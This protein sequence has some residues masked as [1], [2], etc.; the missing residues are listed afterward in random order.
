M[1]R[2]TTV[3]A[4]IILAL[5]A[6]LAAFLVP[7]RAVQ[8]TGDA[9][10]AVETV[11]VASGGTTDD[12][13][14]WV[15]PAEPTKS[16]IIGA[17]NDAGIGIYDLAGAE[18]RTITADGPASSVDVR[19]GFT[20]GGQ[21]VDILAA[22]NNGTVRFYTIDAAGQVTNQTAGT[23]AITPAWPSGGGKIDGLC[24]YQSSASG[25]P[26]TYAFVWAPTGQMEQLELIDN[27]GKIDVRLVRGGALGAWDVAATAGPTLSGCVADDELHTL[28][29]GEKTAAI[30]KFG[31]EPSASIT[32][33]ASVDVPAPTGHFTPNLGGLALV[34]TGPETGYLMASS[35]G[36]PDTP[37]A[38]SFMVYK[39]EG[40]N[41]FVR[42]FHVVTGAVDGCQKTRGIEAVAANLGPAFPDGVFVCQDLHNTATSGS[43]AGLQDYKLVPLGTIADVT[44]VVAQTTTTTTAPGPATTTTAPAV[45]QPTARRS[46]YWMVG[47]D[48]KVYPFGDAKGLGDAPVMPG[49]EA[50]DLEPTPSG[51]GYW[52]VDAAGHVYAMGDAGWLGNADVTKLAAGEKVTSISSTR[53]GNGYWIFTTRGRVLP[54]GAAAFHGDMSDIVLNG[55]VLDSIPS[56]SGNGYYMVASDGGIFTL[57]D[58]KFLGSMGDTKLN[59][60]VQSLV[61]SDGLGYWLVASDGGIFA[62][63]DAPFRG[64][65]GSAKL[66]K[67]VT[68][69]VR[70]GNGYLMVAEDGGIF[71]FSDRQ[72]FGSLGDR[73]PAHKVVSVAALDVAAVPSA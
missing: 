55:P 19:R 28:Y 62:F 71:N 34:R 46:G 25:A 6:S 10:A 1:S 17:N 4:L 37:E 53:S 47:S 16:L 51:N 18:K 64:S 29:V 54:V 21:A 38:D 5:V 30:W 70:F 42:S 14:V 27:A 49:T 2:R 13:A 8:P 9:S 63:G 52:I 58:A 39:R 33:P 67:P 60:P 26:K 43:G 50:V 66:N 72:F 41:E 3:A 12:P 22:A 35:Q 57:G 31:A 56:A 73:P 69:M 45:V 61:P 48:G 65:L 7:A 11:P 15:D 40:A 24:L 32:G 23:G 68:G 20:L 44:P 36:T 59:A